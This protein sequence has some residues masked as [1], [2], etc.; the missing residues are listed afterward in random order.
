MRRRRGIRTP[1]IQS[2]ATVRSSHQR[3]AAICSLRQIRRL[4]HRVV[5][6]LQ[7]VTLLYSAELP[8]RAPCIAAPLRSR[9]DARAATHPS[10]PVAPQ[11]KAPQPP[12][13]SYRHHHLPIA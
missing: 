1:S 9:R 7:V 10:V 13:V 3:A 4:Q 8:V 11:D 6:N 2:A 5:A 12:L